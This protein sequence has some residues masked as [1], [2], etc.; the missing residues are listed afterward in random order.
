METMT[1]QQ[2]AELWGVDPRIVTRYVTR[3]LLRKYVTQRDQL[4][5]PG[6]VVFDAAEVHR[7]AVARAEDEQSAPQYLRPTTARW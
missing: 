6:R 5:R 1:R 2:A 7:I 3:G 4:G